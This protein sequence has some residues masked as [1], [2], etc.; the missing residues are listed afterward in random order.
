MS[1]FAPIIHGGGY[2]IQRSSGSGS[3]GYQSRGDTMDCYFFDEEDDNQPVYDTY[4]IIPHAT[5]SLYCRPLDSFPS[6]SVIVVLEH[7]TTVSG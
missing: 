6:T 4:D 1:G 5:D 7:S 2:I 3:R